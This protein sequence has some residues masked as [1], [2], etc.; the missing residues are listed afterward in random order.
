MLG[1]FKICFIPEHWFEWGTGRTTSVNILVLLLAVLNI[2]L[3][4]NLDKLY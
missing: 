1:S 4:W 3:T 2:G